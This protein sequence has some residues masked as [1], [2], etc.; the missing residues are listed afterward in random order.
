[1]ENGK[2]RTRSN[3]RCCISGVS[4]LY[5]PLTS[6]GCTQFPFHFISTHSLWF[7]ISLLNST[8]FY[9]WNVQRGKKARERELHIKFQ[10]TSPA[11]YTLPCKWVCICVYIHEFIIPLQIK[12]N[13]SY[14][15]LITI[16]K[17]GDFG[18]VFP[19]MH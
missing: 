17:F 8:L 1:M 16:S 7:R 3:W 13:E 12:T 4:E 18:D 10:I 14:W 6:A 2:I 11:T 19:R 9:K 15:K 5:S